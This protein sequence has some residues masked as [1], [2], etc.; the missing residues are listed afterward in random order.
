Y[1]HVLNSL[2]VR[3]VT[4]IGSRGRPAITAFG[5]PAPIGDVGMSVTWPYFDGT[6]TDL[7][8]AQ[9]AQKPEILSSPLDIKLGTE[10]LV[11]YAGGAD[12]AFQLI[13]Q[14]DPSVL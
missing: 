8:A 7:G 10:A 1:A 3:R 11:T 13:R 4:G 12:I 9:S 2:T 6:L 14:A 5:G